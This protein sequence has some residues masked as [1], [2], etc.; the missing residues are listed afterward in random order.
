MKTFYA[1]LFVCLTLVSMALPV[2]ARERIIDFHSDII[3]QADGTLDV[4]ETIEVRAEGKRIRRGIYRDFPTRYNDGR[5]DRVLVGFEVVGVKRDGQ[6]EPW[7]TENL[8]NGVRINTG[9][10]RFLPT[11][12]TTRYE[13]RYRTTR[14]VGFF[15]YH[16][17]LYWNVTGTDWIFDIES[18]SARVQLPEAVPEDRLV[19]DYYTGPQGS[20]AQDARAEVVEPGVVE[21][22]TTEPLGR[23][24]GLTLVVSFPKGIVEEP[25]GLQRLLWFL[26]DN[27]AQLILLL[28][29]LAAFGYYL[30]YWRR[31]GRDPQAG[32][33][34]ARYY[35]PEDFSPGGLRYL[36]KAFYDDRCFAA[37]LVHMSVK[38][39]V[40]IRRER[41]FL[42]DD[43]WLEK[44]SDSSDA[45]LTPSERALFS[46]LFAAG[47]EIELD[48]KNHSVLGEAMRQHKKLVKRRF[49]PRYFVDNFKIT[50]KVW[51][52]SLVVA[53]LA[54]WLV[55][56]LAS[57]T[58]WGL[59]SALVV[60]NVVFAIL[61]RRP[62]E[63]GRR[64]LDHIEGLKLYMEV[65]S[66]DDIA[67]LEHRNPDEP[68]LNAERFESL[69]PYALA[70]DVESAWTDKFTQA[71]GTEAATQATNRMHWYHGDLGRG[72]LAG[73][74][75]D[76]GQ[77]LSSQ[78]ASSSS[79]PGSSSGAG[80]GGAS[81]GG[82]GGGGGGGR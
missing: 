61:M 51:L 34:F 12:L 11:P 27:R 54:F 77:S 81:G 67:R 35:P 60:L 68:P 59:L 15:E 14:Q 82:G 23:R 58:F 55:G 7:F 9:N 78:I 75:N 2:L 49:K 36:S 28:G 38:G 25:S 20:R 10:D 8:S 30:Y 42:S 63:E 24:E 3:V 64:L 22:T 53:L 13:I 48:Q 26:Q 74:S 4:T 37:D 33:I 39:R 16:D 66:K 19:L 46:H 50:L 18:A 43:W 76:L 70:L 57:L 31:E 71:V 41:N 5:G 62:T 73:L 47:N 69:L 72:G 32:P 65:A 56:N 6:P 40:A 52:A 79:P 44:R 21:F 1:Q 80:G 29:I 17:G 45:D